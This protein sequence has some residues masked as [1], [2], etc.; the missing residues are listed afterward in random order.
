MRH[1]GLLEYCTTKLP[2][3]ANLPRFSCLD[4][5]H[6]CKIQEQYQKDLGG[7]TTFPKG[8]SLDDK[9]RCLSATSLPVPCHAMSISIFKNGSSALP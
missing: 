1:N 5:R 9:S 7:C 8:S 3:V 6:A 2:C 4:S